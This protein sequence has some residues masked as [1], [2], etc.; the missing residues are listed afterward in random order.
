MIGVN[1]LGNSKPMLM[2]PTPAP[3]AMTLKRIK[4]EIK[5]LQ[6]ED[7]GDIRLSPSEQSML[8]WDGSIPGPSGSP[9]EGGVFEFILA[10][11]HDYPFTAPNI[12]FK[13][14][15][16]HMNISQT[17]HICLD[18]LKTAWSPALSLFKV[19]LSLSSLLTDPNPN[20]PLVTSIAH[21]YKKN[22]AMHDQTARNWTELYA[23]KAIAPVPPVSTPNSRPHTRNGNDSPSARDATPSNGRHTRSRL[24]SDAA[25]HP[26][27]STEVINLMEED[28]PSAIRAPA[29]RRKRRRGEAADDSVE[30]VEPSGSARER[31]R[32]RLGNDS[33]VH[34]HALASEVI[35]IDD[36]DEPVVSR[37]RSVRERAGEV[38]GSE[39][40][41]I[42][43]D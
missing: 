13:T 6:Q 42:E 2:P 5:D 27:P 8:Q 37:N 40:I 15:I 43:D 25:S 35:E 10:L 30:D 41:V 1:Y 23:K 34:G 11:P 12:T 32:R 39:V 19:I 24:R 36:D 31:S 28:Q 26:R 21:E 16:Y 14:Q 18:I 33:V 20:D 29:T 17:G 9:Y 4:R 38:S 22:R 7:M 3:S